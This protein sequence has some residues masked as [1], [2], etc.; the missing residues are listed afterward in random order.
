[1]MSELE[2]RSYRAVFSLE[3]RVYQIDTLRLN[4]GGV[5]LRGLAY[6][7]TLVLAALAARATP[8]IS[9][10]LAPLPWYLVDVAAPIAVGALLGVL[11]I[12]GRPFHLA[13]GALLRLYIGPRHS[14]RL[15]RAHLRPRVWLPPPIVMIPDGSDARPRALR[16]HGPGAVL[17]AFAHDRVEWSQGPIRWPRRDVS[18]HPVVGVRSARAVSLEIAD[19][20]RL[21]VATTPYQRSE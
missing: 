11:R 7:A 16:Y 12:E 19:G 13:A 8:G 15:G 17:V 21:E 1:M 6:C 18:L 2:V 9:G 4:P 3:R 5:P 14:W 10:V 20:A